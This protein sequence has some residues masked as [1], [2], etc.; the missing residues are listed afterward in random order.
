VLD[1]ASGISQK[2]DTY[3]A[4]GDTYT[5]PADGWVYAKC[6]TSDTNAYI[7]GMV[8]EDGG[9]EVYGTNQITYSPVMNLRIIFPVGAGRSFKII[10]SNLTVNV[11]RFIYSKGAL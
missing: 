2:W 11:F 9:S 1:Q 3:G 5:A 4:T 10:N 6:V 8:M 7:I